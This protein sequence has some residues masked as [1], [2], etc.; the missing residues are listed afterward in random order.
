LA[1]KR[2]ADVITCVGLPQ[3]SRLPLM[4][5]D[6]DDEIRSSMFAYLGRVSDDRLRDVTTDQ[7]NAFQFEGER[8]PLLQHMRGIRV[9][10]GMPA[11]LTIRTT[12]SARPEDRPYEDSEGADGYYRYKWRG[13]DADASDNRA[14]RIAMVER[15]PLAWFVGVAP[16]RFAAVYPVWLV[17]E[18]A[19]ET[20]FVVAFDKTMRDDWSPDR[21]AH[22]ADLALRRQYAQATVRKRLHQPVFRQRVLVAYETRCALCRLRHPELLDAAHIKEDSDGGEPIVPNGVAMCA[23]HHRAFDS[24]VIG[25]RPD[26]MIQVRNDVL[27]EEDGPTLRHALQELHGQRLELPR[28]RRAWP[29][30]GLLDARFERFRSAS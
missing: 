17:D 29:D 10:A 12:F 24:D 9:V 6:R 30:T 7:L 18:E 1:R 3:L 19:D 8:L 14:L 15:R 11:A 25:I 23:I 4:A 28:Q 27:G 20:Q 5:T 2:R 13:T 16:G 26:F 21:F 22:P